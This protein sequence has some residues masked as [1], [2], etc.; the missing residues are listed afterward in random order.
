ME[1]QAAIKW[2]RLLYMRWEAH[3]ILFGDKK[4]MAEKNV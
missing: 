2:R 4:Q 3:E 1:Y